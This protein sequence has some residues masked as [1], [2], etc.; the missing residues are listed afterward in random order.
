MR[1]ALI[2]LLFAVVVSSAF[3]WSISSGTINSII[4]FGCFIVLAILGGMLFRKLS[5]RGFLI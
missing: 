4:A 3:V 1:F 5:D 2:I